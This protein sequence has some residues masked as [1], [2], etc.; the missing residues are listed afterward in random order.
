MSRP[1]MQSARMIE[2]GAL[3]FQADSRVAIKS[4]PPALQIARILT[5]HRLFAVSER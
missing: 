4:I 2:N 3:F 1:T 5:D